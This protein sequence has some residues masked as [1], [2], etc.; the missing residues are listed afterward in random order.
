MKTHILSAAF[1]AAVF[2]AGGLAIQAAT[3]SWDAGGDGVST[4]QEANWVVDDNTGQPTWV[5]GENPP[6]NSVNGNT[7]VQADAIVGGSATAGGGGASANYRMATDQSLTVQDDATFRMANG[8]GIAAGTGATGVELFIDDNGAV[9][10]Q[11]LAGVSV[12]M[13]GASTLT[14]NGGGD[15]INESFIDLDADWTGSIIMNNETPADWTDPLSS[16]PGQPPH[17]DDITV[18]GIPAQVGINVLIVSDGGTGSILTRGPL[19]PEPTALGLV[20]VL[21][22]LG[23]VRQRRR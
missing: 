12:E 22:A 1:A 17:I 16:N 5:V 15:P 6:A 3:I 14:L 4:F 10:S 21:A 20:S 18:A 23:A 19:I 2:S 7:A 9:I 8:I 13:S 11:F